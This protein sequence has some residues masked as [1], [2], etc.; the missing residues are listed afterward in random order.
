MKEFQWFLSSLLNTCVLV[1]IWVCLF[2]FPRYSSM[3][4]KG[5]TRSK[6]PCYQKSYPLLRTY[7]LQSSYLMVSSDINLSLSL[8]DRVAMPQ[9]ILL[10]F[11]KRFQFFINFSQDLQNKNKQ[12][13]NLIKKE[14]DIRKIYMYLCNTHCIEIFSSGK[15]W[16]KGYWSVWG[17]RKFSGRLAS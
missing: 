14:V 9:I 10:K 3:K 16:Q 6:S 12:V 8:S 2:Q 5:I 15:H 17:L 13:S 11:V 4:A 7:R 1:P